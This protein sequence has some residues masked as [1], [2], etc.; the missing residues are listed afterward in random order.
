M[1]RSLIASCVFLVS[2]ASAT[3]AQSNASPLRGA[4]VLVAAIHMARSCSGVELA[5]YSDEDAFIQ[6]ASKTLRKQ[7]FRRQAVLKQV[8]YTRTED[9]MAASNQ[10]LAGVGTSLEDKRSLCAHANKVA[11][12]RDLVGQFLSK[13]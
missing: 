7:G 1:L 4:S 3:L 10:L 2:I 13:E 9:L 5:G 11:N 12:K 8:Y 6:G